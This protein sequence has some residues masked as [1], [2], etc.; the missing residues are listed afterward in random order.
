MPEPLEPCTCVCAK[1]DDVRAQV[2]YRIRAELV[3]CD[4]YARMVA[5]ISERTWDPINGHDLTEFLNLKASADY[6]DIC[7]FGE[8]AARLVE[9]HDIETRTA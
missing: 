9:S 3:C 8:W 7:Y 2:A 1:H 4:I 6:H 5:T